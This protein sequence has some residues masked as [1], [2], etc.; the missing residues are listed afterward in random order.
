[1]AGEE[2][3]GRRSVA[4]NFSAIQKRGRE[5]FE[6]LGL[7]G[8]KN[9]DWKYTSLAAFSKTDFAPALNA[10]LWLMEPT[11]LPPGL[12]VEPLNESVAALLSAYQGDQEDGIKALNSANLGSGTVIRVARGVIVE[13]PIRLGL[14]H[15]GGA[16]FL[17]N[18]F[19]LEEGAQAQIVEE[20]S[21]GA[22]G[23]TNIVTQIVLGENSVLDHLR[24]QNENHGN[25]HFSDTRVEQP[26]SS[27]YRSSVVS[28][29][30]AVVR[31]EI[32]ARLGGEGAECRLL[33]LY[34]A[35]G[36]QQ[37][38]CFTVVDHAV[39]HCQ[40]H[41]LYKGVLDDTAKGTFT[42]KI[43][44]R[45]EA[46]KTDANQLNRNL[47]LSEG[48]TANTRPQLQID[49]DDVKCSHGATIG[50]LDEEALFYLRSRGI[51][52]QT[53]RKLLTQAF[54]SEVI[55]QMP[56]AGAREGLLVDFQKW[57][58]VLQA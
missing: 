9:E 42:G 58:G 3:R 32:R 47:L 18:I 27:R 29:G 1:M 53:A 11:Q 41:E 12:T 31:N 38:D 52:A 19:I 7:P 10:R 55:E 50:R 57:L 13:K 28:L 6:R 49:A 15:P 51:E 22:S 44:V 4:V 45:P 34:A 24:I 25:F 2:A 14:V 33:G 8:V 43:V 35:K 37:V 17:H 39:P 56:I 23:A 30:G 26:R 5:S 54:A 21:G 20:Y 48:A 46:Q 16:C 36:S 40:S